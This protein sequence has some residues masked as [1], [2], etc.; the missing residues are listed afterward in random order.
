MTAEFADVEVRRARTTALLLGDHAHAS[1]SS[2]AA[3]VGALQAQDYSSG[4]WSLGI[5]IPGATARSVD[6]AFASGEV[7]RT[8]PMRGTIHVVALEDARWML[9]LTGTRTL[10]ATETRRREV[11]LE[12]PGLARAVDALV[13]AMAGRRRISRAHAMTTI[14]EA[15]IDVRGQA[16][17][18]VLVYAALI[19][20][21]CIGPNEGATQTIVRLDEWAT[22]Q[23]ELSGLDALTELAWRY[24]R[25]HGPVT[26]AEFAGW[27]GLTL[28]SARA[29]IAA[30]GDRVTSAA[31]R[32]TETWLSREAADEIRCGLPPG[33]TLALPGFDE[34]ILATRTG[35]STFRASTCP[36]SSP[37]ATACSG[38]RSRSTAQSSRPGHARIEPDGSTSRSSRSHQS[39]I[40]TRRS[41]V[42]LWSAT[43]GSAARYW[44]S[45]R[46]RWPDH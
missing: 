27:S 6:E 22:R 5:R 29:G 32:G 36:P 17:Y 4:A 43:R 11:G 19:G 24:V 2:V 21:I 18:H 14:G 9:A 31:F 46:T 7:L 34:F 1:P 15:G 40:D 10:A 16:G 28:T 33:G 45:G 30:N 23:R 41:S 38:R 8:W 25:S 20:A 13:G 26:A 3:W 35:P 39:R 44:V 37:G 12:Q 42:G